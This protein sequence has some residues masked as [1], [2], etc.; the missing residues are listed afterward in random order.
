[1]G[2]DEGM[3]AFPNWSLCA[4]EKSPRLS[5][6]NHRSRG[7]LADG[8]GQEII[9]KMEE[10]L[11][12]ADALLV[13]SWNRLSVIDRL[14]LCGSGLVLIFS[15][16]IVMRFTKVDDG[17]SWRL[18]LLR[19]AMLVIVGSLVAYDVV[20][21]L[22]QHPFVTRSIAV[23]LVIFVGYLTAVVVHGLITQRF[24]RRRDIN[25]EQISTETYNSRMLSLVSGTMI[26]AV[27][28]VAVIQIL[29]FEELLHAGGV[30]GLVGVMLALTQSS[31]APD[32]IGGLVILNS[33]MIEEDD[34]L[35]ISD[36]DRFLA[37]V[38]RT[39]MFHTEL[40][41]LERNNRVMIQNSR[42]RGQTVRNLSKFASAAGLR[43]RLLYNIAYDIAEK[44]VAKLFEKVFDN[45]E[46]SKDVAIAFDRGFELMP[47]AADN[48][49]VRWAFLYHIKEVR[50]LLSTRASI[51]S[52]VIRVAAEEG[53]ALATPLLV[54]P[55]PDAASGD[56]SRTL[57]APETRSKQSY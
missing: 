50:K 28:S 1:M 53:I 36:G 20:L 48:Y 6:Q 43:E 39:K 17:K 3:S 38:F 24:G 11:A 4:V 21:P 26:F 14:L 19:S 41:D 7:S 13:S 2:P 25:G 35:E 40:L 12:I 33:G 27:T 34:V 44:K 30:F 56:Q 5:T 52:E 18:R 55:S 37:V 31:W 16:Q 51:N 32:L 57:V 46:R 42:L 23:M 22:E 29:G 15:R 10:A 54:S 8:A 49:S 47:I 9:Q 45:L